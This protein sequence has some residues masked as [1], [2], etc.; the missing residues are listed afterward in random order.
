MDWLCPCGNGLN[1]SQPVSDIGC[2]NHDAPP[3]EVDI[4]GDCGIM[5]VE[6]TLT[7]RYSHQGKRQGSRYPHGVVRPTTDGDIGLLLALYAAD[8]DPPG[9]GN[10]MRRK[11]E[12]T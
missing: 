6:P 10:L 2:S 9:T 4:D 11:V 5:K 7:I 8:H 12:A 3:E 1:S